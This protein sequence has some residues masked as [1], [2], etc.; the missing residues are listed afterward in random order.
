MF[1]FIYGVVRKPRYNQNLSVTE[2][3]VNVTCFP[4]TKVGQYTLLKSKAH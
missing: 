3:V 2:L 4:I 1:F